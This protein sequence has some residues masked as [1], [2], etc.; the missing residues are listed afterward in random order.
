VRSGGA[1]SVDVAHLE[2]D[3]CLFEDNTTNVNATIIDV[4]GATA[5]GANTTPGLTIRNSTFLNNAVVGTHSKSNDGHLIYSPTFTVN[6]TGSYYPITLYNNTFVGN[7]NVNRAST[8]TIYSANQNITMAG[9]IFGGNRCKDNGTGVI[10]CNDVRVGAT[11]GVITSYGYNIYY[12]IM[13]SDSPMQST[14][15]EYREWTAAPYVVA[16]ANAEGVCVPN[17]T[18]GLWKKLKVIPNALLIELLGEDPV[19]Q[20]GAPRTSQLGFIG[21]YEFPSYVL[22]MSDDNYASTPES[23]FAAYKVGETAVLSNISPDF[24]SWFINEQHY[25]GNPYNLIMD[26]DYSVVANYRA[27]A[28]PNIAAGKEQISI[29]GNTLTLE[30]LAGVSVSIYYITGAKIIS[31]IVAS[32]L[33]NI[34]LS[35]LSQGIYVVKAGNQAKKIIK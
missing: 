23:G 21:A 32:N 11:P 4:K 6:S 34:D 27:L 10:Y 25:T 29:S 30:N 24:V 14:D 35:A 13:P 3:R 15:K 17:E 1:I 12:G 18:D 22:E 16:T 26:Q 7:T 2:I 9:N 28:I 31:Q 5:S 33:E 20:T 8:S 19:D